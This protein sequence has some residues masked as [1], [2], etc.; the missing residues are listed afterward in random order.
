MPTS[1]IIERQS[2][3]TEYHPVE[4][5][6]G[7]I[8]I[9]HSRIVS[10]IPSS[11][12]PSPLRKMELINVTTDAIGTNAV[13]GLMIDAVLVSLPLIFIH[14]KIKYHLRIST[15]LDLL[16]DLCYNISLRH[17]I[18]SLRTPQYEK[19]VKIVSH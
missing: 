4:E 18:N 14:V 13:S 15:C 3:N 2:S 6:K 17:V 19:V 9:A 11:C 7:D 12:F 5:L 10:T 1:T 8:W 16:L